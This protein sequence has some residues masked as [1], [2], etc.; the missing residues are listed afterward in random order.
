MKDKALAQQLILERI[1]TER[2]SMAGK[3]TNSV[4]RALVFAF[5]GDA[6]QFY[7]TALCEQDHRLSFN[8]LGNSIQTFAL[9]VD[10]HTALVDE[11]I[12]KSTNGNTHN[13]FNIMTM[14]LHHDVDTADAKK[15]YHY[16]RGNK[17]LIKTQYLAGFWQRLGVTHNPTSP[18]QFDLE[19]LPWIQTDGEEVPLHSS[20]LPWLPGAIQH[21]AVDGIAA[22]S[23]KVF[24][25]KNKDVISSIEKAHRERKRKDGGDF[26]KL[27]STS[28]GVSRVE[29]GNKGP[30]FDSGLRRDY[31]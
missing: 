25:E 29:H 18:E 1:P 2:T 10:P 9:G 17:S 6:K 31:I 12:P 7:D 5:G 21:R 8:G 20:L 13:P 14:M 4:W 3:G 19:P 16:F 28:T 24:A 27:I 22:G 26:K 11:L 30:E 23:L 15:C